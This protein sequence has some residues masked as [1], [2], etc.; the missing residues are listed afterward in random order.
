MTTESEVWCQFEF[1][2]RV[3]GKLQI[4]WDDL[5]PPFMRI[6]T[7]SVNVVL[8][9]E[10]LTSSC[11]LRN[12]I[13]FFV[14]LRKLDWGKKLTRWCAER[15]TASDFLSN[16]AAERGLS[17]FPLK[18]T[19]TRS[20]STRLLKW[21]RYFSSSSAVRFSAVL[22]V[23]VALPCKISSSF[24]PQ[25]FGRPAS[26]KKRGSRNTSFSSELKPRQRS[27]S[28]LFRL[29]QPCSSCVSGTE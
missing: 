3:F 27:P 12:K 15:N 13:Q 17:D 24:S 4:C 10:W 25:G 6:T 22:D 28:R 21:C 20:M 18:L 16:A 8:D 5:R 9:V 19:L 23:I 14:I 29:S 7:D 2:G 1:F 26:A 11:K